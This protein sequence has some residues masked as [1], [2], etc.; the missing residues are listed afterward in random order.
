VN[1]GDE[2]GSVVG[3]VRFDFENFE[4]DTLADL[5]VTPGGLTPETTSLV[6]DD[7]EI[8]VATFN[9]LNLAPN[10]GS[11]FDALAAIIVSNLGA[12][13]IVALQEIMDDSGT[14]DDGTV[15]AETTF[16]ALI[17]A[18]EAVDAGLA[19]VYDYAQIDPVDGQ[20][21][22]V[23]GG[24][25]RVGFLFRTDRVELAPGTPGDSKTNVVVLPGPKLSHNPGRILDTQLADGDAF[26]ESRKPL[27]AVFVFNGKS[28]FL[29]ANHF[30]SKGGTSP[31]TGRLSL[32]HWF[33]KRKGRAGEASE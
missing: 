22:G 8:T 32:P 33:P 14:I 23:P 11:R 4:I 18:I 7:D 2:L 3:V 6:G 19:G 16:Q 21:G 5:V 17:A 25:I 10:A 24:N 9:V 26:E 28:V 15:A 20:D 1:V 31:S 13:D 27:A 29:V 12:P 30:N